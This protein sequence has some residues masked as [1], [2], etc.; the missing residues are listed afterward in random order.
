MVF[1]YKII[2]VVYKKNVEYFY[3]LLL[4]QSIIAPKKMIS[5][6]HR[7][8]HFSKSLLFLND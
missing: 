6:S 8:K 7:K 3:S 5:I 4:L 1:L 2:L